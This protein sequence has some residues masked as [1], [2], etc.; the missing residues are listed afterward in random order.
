MSSNLS[1]FLQQARAEV[2]QARMES[3]IASG[4]M[5]E[6]AIAMTVRYLGEGLAT[7]RGFRNDDAWHAHYTSDEV[8][9]QVAA[10]Q[11]EFEATHGK[12]PRPP[13][14]LE[15]RGPGD[16]DAPQ[17][18]QQSQQHAPPPSDDTP[19]TRGVYLR[20]VDIGDQHDDPRNLVRA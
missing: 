1:S 2:A 6:S 11:D 20:P 4:L 3:D 13:I 19:P 8:L 5:P 17:Q 12:T 16:W 7:Y 15:P 14:S 18:S 9:A 10:R